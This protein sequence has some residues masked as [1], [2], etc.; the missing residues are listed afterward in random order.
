MISEK[1]VATGPT[2]IG[3]L[4]F[5]LLNK[6]VGNKDLSQGD[7]VSK[8]P[9]VN[10]YAVEGKINTYIVNILTYIGAQRNKLTAQ[11]LENSLP[12]NKQVALRYNP[13]IA[14]INTEIKQGVTCRDFQIIFDGPENQTEFNKV[15]I[16]FEYSLIEGTQSVEAIIVRDNDLD[17]RVSRGTITTPIDGRG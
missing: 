16:Q 8:E 7:G 14:E 9:L 11:Q 5:S 3:D 1:E 12:I 17:P 6:K 13:P 4:E 2:K 10:I 15:H